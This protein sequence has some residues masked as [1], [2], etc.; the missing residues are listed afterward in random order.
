MA[1]SNMHPLHVYTCASADPCM[2]IHAV[3]QQTRGG[4]P[5][6]LV[7]V[8]AF[9]A[10]W[11]RLPYWS[12]LPPLLRAVPL[13]IPLVERAY[14]FWARHRLKVSGAM[15]SLGGGSACEPGPGGACELGAGG[16]QPGAAK[17]A[18]RP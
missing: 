13:A 16:A 2:L 9:L 11:E 18:A 6:T 7:G 1:C 14:T 17:R 15:R 12:V 8:P 5:R 4:A 3:E 10:V